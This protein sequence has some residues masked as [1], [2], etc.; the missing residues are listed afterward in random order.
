M[1]LALGCGTAAVVAL[2]TGGDAP[3][4]E[5]PGLAERAALVSTDTVPLRDITGSG[6]DRAYLFP[7]PW[8]RDGIETTVGEP[9]DMPEIVDD[10][11]AGIAVFTTGGR[12]HHAITVR[13]W[14]FNDHAGTYGPNTT[15]R[16]VHGGWLE[17]SDPQH[18]G[19]TGWLAR[20]GHG[21]AVLPLPD[22]GE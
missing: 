17:L 11:N 2:Q 4:R 13:P 14:P 9:L 20:G 18:A 21:F 3:L 1:A 8:T 16:R 15:A 6:W 7:G 5:D 10:E 22:L 12:V 19:R